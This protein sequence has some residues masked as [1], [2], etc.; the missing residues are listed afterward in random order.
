MTPGSSTLR[1][2]TDYRGNSLERQ[3][4]RAPDEG[5]V[6]SG[7]LLHLVT[8]DEEDVQESVGTDLGPF[9]SGVAGGRCLHVRL[10]LYGGVRLHVGNLSSLS[11]GVYPLD[12]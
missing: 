11:D 10:L 3:Q 12:G 4:R 7:D 6:V 1:C 9:P 8:E 2:L 5:L